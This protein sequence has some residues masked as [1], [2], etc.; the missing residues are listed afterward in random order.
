M[1]VMLVVS[2][3]LANPAQ[4]QDD[5]EKELGWSFVA[6]L[7]AVWTGGNSESSTYGLDGTL[8]YQWTNSF[9]RFQAGG[10]QTESSLKTRTAVGVSP[11]DY[12]LNVETNTEKTA[13][14][15]YA[16]GRYDRQLAKNF[17]AVGGVDWLRNTFAGIDSRTLVGVGASNV[18]RDDERFRFETGYEFT[19]TFQAEVVQNPFT[20]NEFPGVRLGYD[21]WWKL[22]ET[23]EFVSGAALDWNLDNTDDVRVLFTAS[24]PVSIKEGLELNPA[25]QL[26]WR[27][28]P[29]LTEVDLTAPDGTPTGDTVLVP[30]EE[31]DTM[32][33]LA[34]VVKI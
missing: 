11:D 14:M 8:R 16:R 29:A 10:T 23:T 32:F 19:Y 12:A 7:A 13:E 15:F 34:L 31:L 33:T 3:G 4:A 25:L 1:A 20:K 26:F 24:L 21:F 9:V 6:N 30:L 5:K 27:N 22:T 28:D 17:H 18:W 2:V